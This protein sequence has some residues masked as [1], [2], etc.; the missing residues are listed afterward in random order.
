MLDETKYLNLSPGDL[1]HNETGYYRFVVSVVKQSHGY[2]DYHFMLIVPEMNQIK[3]LTCDGWSS[4][5]WK[6]IK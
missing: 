5:Y 2:D 6:I 3:E 4:K 1:I